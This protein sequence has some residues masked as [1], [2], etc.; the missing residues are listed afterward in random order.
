MDISKYTQ[1]NRKAWNEV[2][3][4]HERGRTVDLA[5]EFKNPAFSTLEGLITDKLMQIGLSG[6][7]V[8]QP[9]C[10]NGREVLSMLNLGAS[11]G[12]GIDIA[13]AFIEEAREYARIAGTNAEF[14]QSDIYELDP[15][16]HEPAD[17]MYISI[18]AFCWLPDLGRLFQILSPMIRPGGHLVIYESH[19]ITQTLG[20][21]DEDEYIHG[22]PLEP[23]H[24]Y[25]HSEPLVYDDGIDYVGGQS[26]KSTT[27]YEFTH[28]L[29]C[30]LNAVIDAGIDLREFWEYPHD[31]S[32]LLEDREERKL[33]PLSY[34]L[35]GQKRT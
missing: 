24:P 21:D 26:Y 14:I 4:Y 28:T 7:R 10:N 32:S 27:K 12:L 33:L 2:Q 19:P 11:S 20:Y 3:P 18:G 8:I 25:F 34:I 22:H 13:D 35:V 15:S 17:L 6:K 30:V 5:K 9:M 1:S 31:I 23:V 29:S 16:A